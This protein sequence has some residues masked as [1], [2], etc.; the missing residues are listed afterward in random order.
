[1]PREDDGPSRADMSDDWGAARRTAPPLGGP[2]GGGGGFGAS[3]YGS[4]SGDG[5]A[6]APG[7]F[8][9]VCGC[10]AK[11]SQR[12]VCSLVQ[13]HAT[14]RPAS[15]LSTARALSSVGSPKQDDEGLLACSREYERSSRG[16]GFGE[17]GAA[18]SFGMADTESRWSRRPSEGAAAA[19]MR[20]SSSGGGGGGSWASRPSGDGA[21]PPMGER[22]RYV[23]QSFLLVCLCS[24]ASLAL[25]SLS[26]AELREGL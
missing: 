16:G 26:S 9:W 25:C 22:P 23:S 12:W 8:R 24:T 5:G 6:G 7:S 19:P 13:G 18:P 14:L 15:H 21:A 1:M 17:G 11:R 20:S 3:R 10:T 4:R 2:G